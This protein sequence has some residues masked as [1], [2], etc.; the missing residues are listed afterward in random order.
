MYHSDRERCIF[1]M[2]IPISL[3]ITTEVWVSYVYQE[4]LLCLG[5]KRMQTL[6]GEGRFLFYREAAQI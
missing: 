4:D 1:H 5:L 6:V 2:G 3:Q